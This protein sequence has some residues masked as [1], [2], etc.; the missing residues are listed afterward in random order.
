MIRRPPDRG[1]DPTPAP[2]QR[3]AMAVL[4]EA[5]ARGIRR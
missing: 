4:D 3:G 2:R 5:R 1:D